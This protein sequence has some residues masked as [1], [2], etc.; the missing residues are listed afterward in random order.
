MSTKL[1]LA[2]ALLTLV[3]FQPGPA[4][5][6]EFLVGGK[7]FSIMGYVTQ[8]GAVSLVEKN[9]PDTERDFQSALTNLF[10]E[11]AYKPRDDIKLYGSGMLTADWMY[12]LKHNDRSWKDKGFADSRKN[13]YIDDQYWQLLKEAHVTWT[14]PNWNIRAG[15]QIVGWGETDGFRLIDQINPL[16]QRRGFAD[17]EFES[18]IIPTWLLKT[19]YFPAHK[20]MWMQDLGFEFI[21]NPNVTW[22]KN[23]PIELGNDVGGIWAPYVTGPDFKDLSPLGVPGLGFIPTGALGA[24]PPP[25]QAAAASFP[26]VASRI[27][28]ADVTLDR[29]R[30]GSTTGMEYAGR[31][32]TIIAD[33][34]ITLNGFYGR[35]NDYVSRSAAAPPRMTTAEDG[36]VIIHPQLEAFYPY[37]KFVG[38][39]F[40][41][42][43]TPL[44]ASFLGGVAPVLR[45]ETFYAFNSTFSNQIT[46]EFV[47][48]DELR[49]A[50]G[51]DWKVKIPLLNP[52]AY[53]TISPQFYQQKIMSY[54]SERKELAGL[55][56]NNYMTTLMITT[57]YLHNKLVP[58][59]FWMRDRTNKA[60][61]FRYQLGYDYSNVWHF[62]IGATTFDGTKE[63]QGFDVFQN[64]DQLYFKVSYK[65]G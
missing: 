8:G 20:P 51:V 43:I 42:D 31:I 53:F 65:W 4:F 46:N 64:K 44:K 11:M 38:A 47:K 60:N 5:S 45:L 63:G 62:V 10:L 35:S 41:R 12:D 55:Y 13:L 57:S 61:F 54:G 58:S 48:K 16:D 21:F 18:T 39:T 19:E 52:R 29:P 6:E 37:F 56:E 28:S 33:S 9:K 15:K 50:I 1:F 40:S 27:G 7:P 30:S 59:F 26:N 36:A 17:V 34:I 3:F 2:V 22:I 32:K 24:L 14:P 23:Q 49:Y 25:L